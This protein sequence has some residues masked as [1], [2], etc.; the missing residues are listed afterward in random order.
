VLYDDFRAAVWP[1]DRWTKFRSPEFDLWDPA[2]EIRWAGEPSPAMTLH[3]PAFSRSHA[4]HVK[5]LMLS[6]TKFEIERSFTVRVDMAVRTFGT[7]R[8]AF[9]LD[10]GDPRL[11]AGAFVTTD[12]ANGMVFDFLVSNDR[13]CPLYERLP[14]AREA[15]GPYPAFTRF[16]DA[17]PTQAGAWHTYEVRYD[18]EADRVAWRVDGDR[19]AEVQRVGAPLGKAAPIV[20]VRRLQIG[21][22]LFTVLDGLRDDRECADDHAPIPGVVAT[23]WEDRF[24]QGGEVSFA[25]FQIEHG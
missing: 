19:V 17:V 18:S 23:T 12:Q 4:H 11:A 24:G 3:I 6:A 2:T 14:I 8:N 16:L 9:G 22:G 21:G 13:I 25:K 5:A 1:S 10:P 7:E 15:H 20:K